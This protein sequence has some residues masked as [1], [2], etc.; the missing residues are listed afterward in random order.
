[1]TTTTP[2]RAKAA[3]ARPGR[4][5]FRQQCEEYVFFTDVCGI[6]GDHQVAARMGV[7]ADAVGRY[8]RWVA[9]HPGRV[10]PPELEG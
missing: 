5:K 1:M 6:F 8:R 4:R 2:E 7:T 10:C 9:A 3:P